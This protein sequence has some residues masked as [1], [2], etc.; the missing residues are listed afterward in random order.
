MWCMCREC[1]CVECAF[2]VLVL[3]CAVLCCVVMCG[4]G[5]GVGA[6]CVVCVVSV[7]SVRGCVLG[8]V[9]RGL[10]RGK[11]PL[12]RFM[13]AFRGHTR[14]RFEPTHGDGLNLHTEKREIPSD[15]FWSRM[16]A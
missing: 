15:G 10:A 4:V 14:K 6:Q 5:A 11:T 12:C 1:V 7:V 2:C 9:W 16:S 13:R 8:C 3:C